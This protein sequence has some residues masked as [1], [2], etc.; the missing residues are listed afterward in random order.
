MSDRGLSDLRDLA[1]GP[2]PPPVGPLPPPAP[3]RLPID[4]DV[5]VAAFRF[6]SRMAPGRTY[7]A[8]LLWGEDCGE[9]VLY[10][11][12]TCW[13][14][15]KVDR[16]QHVDRARVL[17][18]NEERSEERQAQLDA[19]LGC[20]HPLTVDELEEDWAEQRTRVHR[21][22]VGCGLRVENRGDVFDR[23]EHDIRE[24]HRLPS[25]PWSGAERSDDPA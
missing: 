4:P 8:A 22:C 5:G 25:S 12:C 7:D 15:L 11:D 19:R 10:W 24:R 18:A 17:L 20:R 9:P 21:E 2:Q 13:P 23:L 3:E 14:F 6:P 16:C 1:P